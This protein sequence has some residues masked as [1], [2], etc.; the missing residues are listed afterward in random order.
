VQAADINKKAV[1]VV[2]FGTTFADTRA[3][4]ID[5]VT[6]KIRE[7]FPD[8]EV[9]QAFTSRIV[10]KKL[11]ERDGLQFDTERQALEKLAEEG[12]QEV[13]VQP[14]HIEAGDE[15]EKIRRVVEEYAQNKTFDKLVLSRPVLYFMGQ[16]DKPD[17]YL[18]AIKA[19]KQQMPVLG[20]EEAVLL[21]GHGG[22]H[23]SNAAYGALQLKV[24]DA[25]IKG[26]YV[27]TVQG[28]PSLGQ[29]IDKLKR[30]NIKKVTLMPFMLVAG[31]HAS[32]DMAGTD[33]DSAKNQLEAA[34]FEVAVFLHGLGENSAVQDIYVQHVKDAIDG[35]YDKKRK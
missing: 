21:M 2:S 13:I 8:Y 3:V 18:L 34:G 31:D 11:A 32:N 17:D 30:E 19:V 28:Y 10:I 27:Y 26:L 9:R 23:P 4:T 24:Q 7:S 6:D 5:A 35:T 14:L 16:E 22:D 1:L 29:T 12:Y 33:K 20:P 25:G 15:Y